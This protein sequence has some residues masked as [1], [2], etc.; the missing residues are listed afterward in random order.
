MRK[1]KQIDEKQSDLRDKMVTPTRTHHPEYNLIDMSSV[2]R[3]SLA[4]SI[5]SR[6][7]IGSQHVNKPLTT[8]MRADKNTIPS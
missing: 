7:G 1:R 4:L 6:I 2:R 3:P 5:N 8:V